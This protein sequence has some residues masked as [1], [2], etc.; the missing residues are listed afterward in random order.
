[1]SYTPYLIA[2][3]ATGFDQERQPW[4]L[5][6]DAQE[7]IYDGYVYRGVWQ[8]RQG[9]NALATGQNG[10]AAYCESRMVARFT[11]EDKGAVG[12]A[13]GAGPWAV[14]PATNLPLRRGTVTVYSGAQVLTDNGL[15]ILAG[16]GSGTIDY[17]TGIANVTFA[18]PLAAVDHIFL[19][20]D[21]HP[22]LPVMMVANLVLTTSVANLGTYKLV[23][24]DT[25]NVNILNTTT[26]RLDVIPFDV[27]VAAYTGNSH[28]FWSWTN[29]SPAAGTSRLIFTNG[30]DPIQS[31][32]GTTVINY[33]SMFGVAPVTYRSMF[34]TQWKDRCVLLR[35]VEGGAR[36]PRR[37]RMGGTGANIDQYDGATAPGAGVVDIPDEGYIMGFAQNRDDLIIFLNNSVWKM[38][39]T[40]SD[41][42]PAS[43]S[44]LDGSRGSNAP[45]GCITYLNRTSGSSSRGFIMTDGYRVERYDN[46]IPD[47]S[48]NQID[49]DNYDLC[50]AGYVDE[51]RDHYLIHPSPHATASD[52]ILVTNYEEDNFAVYRIPLS[53]MGNYTEVFDTTWASLTAANGFPTWYSLDEKY[54]NWDALSYG[55]G[56]PIAVGGGHCGEIWRLNVDGSEDNPQ[57]IRNITIVDNDT[58]EV[59]TDWN[60]Y[61]KGDYIYLTGVG[62]MTDV[63]KK[64]NFI[65]SVTDNYVFRMKFPGAFGLTAY[66]S[67]GLASK[68]I[69]FESLTKKLNPFVD[70]AAK[71]RCS[72]LYF[73][74]TASGVGTSDFLGNPDNC[75]IDVDVV[76]NDIND[77]IYLETAGAALISQPFRIN[78][79]PDERDLGAKRWYKIYINQTARFLQFKVSN[80]QA[81]SA[82]QIHAIMPGLAPVGRLI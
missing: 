66:T 80:Q 36:Y 28:N 54:R 27:A 43:L 6:D 78:C 22:G 25:R 65:K 7:W 10:G 73:Y 12:G 70:K 24:A 35:T 4:L 60:N 50:F 13:G 26:N 64:Q 32:D 76:Q 63:N 34:V 46:K 71:V 57:R 77:F 3:F 69:H 18:A 49:S 79:M 42:V 67:G 75:Y 1:M 19:T 72:Y 55:A 51:D 45:H 56:E 15:G 11:A 62:G 53:C 74:V 17:T 39:Y 82:I 38:S 2:N 37:I 40:G 68:V 31:T 20:Y 21:Q 16:D 48:Y 33:A 5:P 8:K 47:Y 29:C 44:K 30:V 23:V 14:A 58:I 59:T 52:R 9:Y 61:Q 41:V 81:L